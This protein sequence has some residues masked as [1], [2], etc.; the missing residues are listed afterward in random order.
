MV[1]PGQD[2]SREQPFACIAYSGEIEHH[3]ARN[4]QTTRYTAAHVISNL[5]S[6]GNPVDRSTSPVS[7]YRWH[8]DKSYYPV[9]PMMTALYAVE[10]PP[11]GGDTEFANTALGYAALAE[12]TKRQI[13]GLR[14]VF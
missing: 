10:L 4:A 12:T 14:V 6:D 3:G 11:R 2:L 1:Y 13:K 8:T 9:P 5:D 7:N